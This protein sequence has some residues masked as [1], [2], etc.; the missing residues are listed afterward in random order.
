MQFSDKLL[1]CNLTTILEIVN[2]Y[3]R[4]MW[5]L[6]FISEKKWKWDLDEFETNCSIMDRWRGKLVL[7]NHVAV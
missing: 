3:H 1:Y 2:M 7:K 5:I 6:F 4:T